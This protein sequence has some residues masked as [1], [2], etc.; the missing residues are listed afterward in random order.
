MQ[1]GRD[2]SGSRGMRVVL[3]VLTGTLRWWGVWSVSPAQAVTFTVNSI[4]DT[5]D[6]TPGDGSCD[7]GGGNCTLRAAIQEANAF[8]GTDNIHFSIAGGGPHTFTPAS[9]YLII[10]EPVVID[11]TTEPDYVG[12]P[13]IELNGTGA[14]AGADGLKIQ[15]GSSTVQGLAI[16]RFNGVGVNLQ[17]AGSNTVEG[18]FLGT[19][20]LGT[21]A[22]ANSIGV[23][24]SASNGNTIG[25]TTAAA[26]NVISGNSTRGIMVQSGATDNLIQGNYIGTDVNGTA[27]L[28]NTTQGIE[29]SSSHGNTIGGSVAGAGNVISGNNQHGIYLPASDSTTIQ[30]NLIGTDV[31]GTADLGNTQSGIVVTDAN[32]NQIG[33][34]TAAARNVISGNDASGIN[35]LNT[36]TTTSNVIQGN[37]I[38][39]NI[40][41]TAA[42]GNG[43]V[44]ILLQNAA[45]NTVGGSASGAG[46][47]V[48]GNGGTG[49]TLS[50]SGSSSNVV[51]GNKVGTNAAGS[52]AIGNGAL[53]IDVQGADNTI[54]G[55]GTARNLISGNGTFGVA[56]QTSGATGNTVAGNY[57]GTD[58]GGTVD[59]GNTLD[60][61]SVATGPKNNTI[62]GSTAGMG[63]LIS[64]NDR[65]GVY[66]SGSGADSNTVA[67]NTIGLT[68]AGTSALANTSGGVVVGG[69][70]S[71]NTLG[72]TSA[73]ARNV[74]SGN[75]SS[76]VQIT[77]AGTRANRVIGNYI[78]LNAAGNAAVA[79]GTSGIILSSATT[80]NTIGGSSAGEANVISGNTQN[81]VS[82]QSAGS[83]SNTIQGNYI[84]TAA[85]GTTGL[86]NG[87]SGVRIQAAVNRNAVG[88][89]ASGAGNVIAHNTGDGIRL[90]TSGGSPT[91]TAILG[92]AIHSNGAVGIDLGIDGATANDAGDGDTGPNNLQNYPTLTS[93][94]LGSTILS[95][96]FNS[97]ASSTFRLEFFSN[98]ACDGSG[99]GEGEIYL[100]YADVTTDGSGNAT[101]TDTFA[102]TSQPGSFLTATAT[103]GS[104]NTSE[105]SPCLALTSLPTPVLV[106]FAGSSFDPNAT[107]DLDWGDVAGASTY[108]LQYATQSDFSD[109]TEVTGLTASVYSF[110]GKLGDDTYYWRVRAFGSGTASVFSSSDSFAIIP[111]MGVGVALLLGLAMVGYVMWRRA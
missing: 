12:T 4:L 51:Q 86:G 94:T 44:G 92:N 43:T 54:G 3:L 87:S 95:G 9:A 8:A 81:G 6:N 56:V 53:G 28:G 41:G 74:I 104:N 75:G 49:I 93:A 102:T 80:S 103:D 62:G 77:G 29:V 42:L 96:T 65:Y 25:S 83:D 7:D 19:D 70:A 32:V 2:R 110:G 52:A 68:A 39:T 107:P 108:S 15:A 17:V 18:C 35:L 36:T 27:D 46:N 47:V 73:G 105:F 34:T 50:G 40:T 67:G 69:T 14:G 10:S 111:V 79:N 98:S 37:Y 26:R 20:V 48:S 38:G 59:L 66:I 64:G 55:S 31:N 72:G 90:Q 84:G 30:G 1:G 63:N 109:S 89:A 57:I 91:Q 45:G 22:Q 33:G 106:G 61:V 23:N 5:G 60:G 58:L 13:V 101:F 85:D 88:G 82:I 11:G 76:G 21:T 97:T 99:N 71:T 78:G 16:N 100:G 24:I